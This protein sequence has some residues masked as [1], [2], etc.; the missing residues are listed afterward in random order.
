MN[1]S[2]WSTH[3]FWGRGYGW[4][5]E[6]RVQLS[7]FMYYKGFLSIGPQIVIGSIPVLCIYLCRQK[8]IETHYT[9]AVQILGLELSYRWKAKINPTSS[10]I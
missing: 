7:I 4:G 10:D 3:N 9:I 6:G 2:K 5:I 8:S 1:M